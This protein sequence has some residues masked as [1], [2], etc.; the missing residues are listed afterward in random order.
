MQKDAMM[1][2][3]EKSRIKTSK[4]GGANKFVCLVAF[5]TAGVYCLA[6]PLLII[7]NSSSNF[8]AAVVCTLNFP[9]LYSR[10]T[11]H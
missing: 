4:F 2:L 8:A 11:Y 9:G 7:W 5:F 6:T 1:C 3:G 10:E